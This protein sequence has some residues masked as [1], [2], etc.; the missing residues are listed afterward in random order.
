MAIYLTNLLL[1]V[2]FGVVLVVLALALY[3]RLQA[4]SSAIIRMLNATKRIVAGIAFVVFPMV[5][6]F[7][8][9]FTR[10]CSARVC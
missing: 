4:L 1:Y 9:R 7:A 5:F 2:F 6:V 8:F 10:V 3:E